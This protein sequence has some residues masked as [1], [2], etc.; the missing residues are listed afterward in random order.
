MA[1]NCNR[2]LG[3][4]SSVGR[5]GRPLY[6][7]TAVVVANLRLC[8]VDRLGVVPALFP[9]TEYAAPS[10]IW[11]DFYEDHMETQAGRNVAQIVELAKAITQNN[12]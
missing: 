10:I 3:A 8:L 12:K 6:V 4:G 1:S 7:T 11:M 2:S 5:L 9:G